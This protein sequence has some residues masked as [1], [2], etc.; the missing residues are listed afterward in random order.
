M[1]EWKKSGNSCLLQNKPDGINCIF[2]LTR[3][4]FFSS[5]NERTFT[6]KICDKFGKELYGLI[7]DW[8]QKCIIG[9]GNDK[10]KV[11]I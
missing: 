11:I 4:K 9:K 3:H 2:N 5:D 6:G 1:R 8:S 10:F 7:G